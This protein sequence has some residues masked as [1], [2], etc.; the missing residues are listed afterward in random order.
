MI[1]DSADKNLISDEQ[2]IS[3]VLLHEITQCEKAREELVKAQA[4]IKHLIEFNPA[5][6]YS[7]DPR[8]DYEATFVSDNVRWLLGYEPGDFISDPRFWVNHIHPDDAPNTR[9]RV[10]EATK[11]DYFVHEYRLRR[12]DGEYRWLRD[13]FRI[14]RDEKGEPYEM[15]GS[16]VDITDRQNAEAELERYRNDLEELVLDRTHELSESNEQLRREISERKKA[17][18]KLSR[19]TRA[20]KAVNECDRVLMRVK[21]EPAL[22]RQICRIVV[23]VAGYRL[24]W[25]GYAEVGNGQRVYPVAQ[26]GFDDGYLDIV[27]VSWADDELGCGPTGTAIRTGKPAIVR[28]VLTD[29]TFAAWRDEALARGYAS[30]IAL[31]LI[32][33]G[34]TLGALNIYAAELNAFDQ[35]EVRLLASL[36]RDL[37]YGI[38]SV[39]LRKEHEQAVEALSKNREQLS[40]LVEA[41]PLAVVSL[42]LQ[43]KVTSWN[44]AAERMLGW[45]E[46]ETLSRPVPSISADR[47]T[48][49]RRFIERRLRGR[50]TMSIETMARR[51]DGSQIAVSLAVAPLHDEEE[52]TV[53]YL[54][55]IADITERK[56]GEEALRASAARFR[57][58]FD[59]APASMVI[60]DRSGV[61]RQINQAFE[62]L[63]GFKRK[64]ILGKS[65]LETFVRPNDYDRTVEMIDLVLRGETL[66][67]V[68]WQAVRPDGTTFY[69]LTNITPLYGDDGQVEMIL[70]VGID[71]TDRKLAEQR[72]KQLEE[73]KKDFYRRTILAATEGKL[74]IT[75]KEDILQL[76][77][78]ELATWKIR[79]GRQL[80]DIRD[81]ISTIARSVGMDPSRIFDFVLVTGEAATNVVKHAKGGQASLHCT[82][83]GLIFVVSDD[84][85]GIDALAL[86]EV[87]L[88]R[89]YTTAISLGMGYKEMISMA[90]KVYLATGPGGTTVAIR[91][92]LHPT[93]EPSICNNLPDTW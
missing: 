25:V 56:R 40:T 8:R 10:V 38:R 62:Q 78:P 67:N 47:M 7:C 23:E 50:S 52:K 20:L 42:D 24:A 59:D 43:G 14:L 76:A 86:P 28:N 11:L 83:D 12:K 91:M 34:Q 71:I 74:V 55:L 22:L 84:G 85:P 39:R 31:P 79:S 33:D 49:C 53:G 18:A 26:A 21:S 46:E 87:A 13:E 30:T 63:T 73:N 37:S 17:V 2:D 36:A 41:A 92:D 81:G 80:A 1:R 72:R 35:Q 93:Q 6:L 19:T 27:V 48:L 4:H 29:P 88:K 3:E 64:Q 82:S 61:V 57:A 15:V 16:W 70:A 45:T 66:R 9:T 69:A 5:V 77:G 68:E 44:P 32:A 58:I 65:M 90:D 60:Y 51:K 75:E 54:G 89:G